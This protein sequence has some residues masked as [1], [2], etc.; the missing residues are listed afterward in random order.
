MIGEATDNL[1]LER[2]TDSGNVTD[3]I[4]VKSSRPNRCPLIKVSGLDYDRRTLAALGFVNF[5]RAFLFIN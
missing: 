1:S 3:D 2:R 5:R 4:L